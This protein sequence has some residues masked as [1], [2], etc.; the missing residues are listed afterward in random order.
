MSRQIHTE[1]V[2][3]SETRHLKDCADI[4]LHRMCHKKDCARKITEEEDLLYTRCQQISTKP[5]C[6]FTIQV[7]EMQH[8]KMTPM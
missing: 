6:I 4:T 8:A 3:A 1:K 2:V 5:P 7:L